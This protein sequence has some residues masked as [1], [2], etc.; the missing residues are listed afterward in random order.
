MK[1]TF[2][3][4]CRTAFGQNLFVDIKNLEAVELNYVG[5]F[6]WRG[7]FEAILFI[8]DDMELPYSYYIKNSDGE[9]IYEDVENH[10]F[11]AP[12]L[13][14]EAEIF[15]EFIFFDNYGTFTTKPF[16]ECYFRDIKRL[17]RQQ[18]LLDSLFFNVEYPALSEDFSLGIVGSCNALGD[19][20]EKKFVK[21]ERVDY[22]HFTL[23]IPKLKLPE[24]FEFKFIVFDIK[25]NKTVRWEDG[26]NR[27]FN[28]PQSADFVRYNSQFRGQICFKAAGVAVPVFSLRSES[29]WGSGEFDDLR[30]LADWAKR[31]GLKAIQILPI[32]D[33]TAAHTNSDSY[34][35]SANS[36]YAL[37]PMYLNLSKIG[38]LKSKTKAS[39]F[40]KKRLELN[41]KEFVDYENVNRLKWDYIS[42]IYLQ[43][44]EN[45]LANDEF[46][47]FFNKN[48]HWLL[49]Y[50][51]FSCLRDEYGSNDFSK[52]GEFAVFNIKK[53]EA[54]VEKN[55]NAV[56]LYYFVQFHLAKQ[57]SEV[58]DYLHAQG[59]ALK[60]DLPIGINARSVEAWIAPELFNLDKS[61]GAPPDD[62][63]ETG[64]NWGFP[65]Y[66]WEKMAQ[67]GYQWWKQ[68]FA[69]MAE[70]FDAFRIDHI[71]GF[72]RIWEIPKNAEWGLLG[73]F[74]P[75]LPISVEEIENYGIQFSI[76]RHTKPFITEWIINEHFG[77]EAQDVKKIF[78]NDELNYFGGLSFKKEFENQRKLI[79]NF[80]ENQFQKNGSDIL[81]SL[82]R[83]HC[84]VIFIEDFNRKNYY[85]PRISM[86]KSQTYNSLEWYEKQ[87]LERLYNNYFFVRHNDF[88][89]SNALKKLPTLLAATDNMLVCGEDLGM[90]PASVPEVMQ[91]LHILS[92][93]IQRMPKN[94]EQEFLNPYLT[95]YLS[96][97]ASGTH[98]MSPLRAWWQ[99]NRAATQRF[100]NSVLFMNG[101][102]PEY[103][104]AEIAE[105]IVC[106]QL[107]ANSMFAILPIQD[108]LAID[109]AVS[110]P[111]FMNERINVP[112]N[113]EHFWC[114]RMHISLEK[115]LEETKFNDKLKMCVEY[116]RVQVF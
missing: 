7:E 38:K 6:M 59:V 11:A 102:A 31:T 98:D 73:C 65:T 39:V 26:G 74:N 21:L 83:L 91:K 82:L 80:P 56:G 28:V 116:N 33:T 107:R 63:S 22:N 37:H 77:E 50:S 101:A 44:G 103:C 66:N 79:Q 9:K 110:N 99:E 18:K 87:P 43:S 64:Q 78:F 68:R 106:E 114:Y 5:D 85:H 71:L 69:N 1:I 34:P 53:I 109:E 81:K 104:T 4:F 47:E 16:T 45:V 57:L 86:L 113:P 76:D 96:V 97:C 48:S 67:N 60:G 32:N 40:E 8:E 52:W 115:L 112:E 70:Y 100:Y 105:K 41:G 58:R 20:D 111:D 27:I 54:Y 14:K 24:R 2:N 62:F 15:D 55:H 92:L 90:V 10:C 19:W 89:K 30:A 61:A 3:V 93:E 75:A 13:S 108:Y 17:G 23:N 84:E 35:Y 94:P 42:E 95:P 36:V 12:K 51:A 29:G 46:R 88:W 72:F 49:P 25:H